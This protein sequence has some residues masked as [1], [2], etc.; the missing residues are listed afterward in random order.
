[1]ATIT[2]TLVGESLVGDGNDTILDYD[3]TEGDDII[4]N[5]TGASAYRI[6][7]ADNDGNAEL[8]FKDSGG[9]DLDGSVTFDGISEADLSTLLGDDDP[10]N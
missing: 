4:A 1:M 9:A 8:I 6:D 3:R 2:K 5:V 10:L 7:D